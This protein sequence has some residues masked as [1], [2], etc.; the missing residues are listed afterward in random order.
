[1]NARMR[2]LLIGLTLVALALPAAADVRLV[3]RA[4]GSKV[5]AN[6]GRRSSA[7]LSA[8]TLD[9]L[10]R[11]RDRR[12]E[13][14]PIIEKY[15]DRYGVD[16]VLVRAVILVESNFDPS[17]V[18]N[19]GARG[20][21]QLMPG[22][23]KRFGVS[24]IHDPDENIRGGVRYLSILLDQFSYDLPRVLASYNAGEN[25]V[26]RYRG[27][28]PYK[29]TRLYVQK[30]MTVYH[31]TPWGSGPSTIRAAS[32]KGSSTLKGGF[33]GKKAPVLPPLATA[34]TASTARVVGRTR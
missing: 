6:D 30:A 23:A 12:T 31:G 25:A 29:E 24:K 26:L 1:M 18:S 8:S 20:L 19:K 22:T 9:W 4:D 2:S 3:V 17:V 13:Y 33:S 16:P 7:A 15:C 11:Q 10:A 34:L 32:S 5:I 27:I 21:M 28:P 14:D